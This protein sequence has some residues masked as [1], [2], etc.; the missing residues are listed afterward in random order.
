MTTGYFYVRLCQAVLASTEAAGVLLGPLATLPTELRRRAVRSLLER[1]DDIGLVSLRELAPVIGQLRAR[2]SL[3]I[4][5][6]EVLAS[7][8]TLDAEVFLSAPS[9]RLEEALRQESRSV[10]VVS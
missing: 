3:N 1:P 4:L 5:G 10:H 2:H 7:A 8:V 9:P 6:M